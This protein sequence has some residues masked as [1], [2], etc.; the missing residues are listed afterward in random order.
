MSVMNQASL[1]SFVIYRTARFDAIDA[2]CG[3]LV[4]RIRARL[5]AY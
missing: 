2:L 4:A 3:A 5:R 1:P